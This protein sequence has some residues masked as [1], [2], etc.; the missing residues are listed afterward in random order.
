MRQPLALQVD[1]LLAAAAEVAREAAQAPSTCIEG[2]GIHVVLHVSHPPNEVLETF[3][4][5]VRRHVRLQQAADVGDDGLM[6]HTSPHMAISQVVSMVA[7][8]SQLVKPAF[9]KA[10][11]AK[12]GCRRSLLMFTM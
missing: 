1:D 4:Q 5:P 7:V 3:I 6:E 10:A 9:C 12:K 11:A 8:P 2:F